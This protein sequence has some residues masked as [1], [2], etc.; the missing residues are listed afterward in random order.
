MGSFINKTQIRKEQKQKVQRKQLPNTEYIDF[1]ADL[2]E[3]IT[4]YSPFANTRRLEYVE[5]RSLLIYI[6]RDVENVTYYGIRD[7]FNSKG[8]KMDHS[9][10]LYSYVNYPIYCKYNPKITAWFNMLM[11]ASN[12]SDAKKIQAKTIIDNSD[13]AVADI[14]IYMYK[15]TK[16]VEATNLI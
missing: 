12:T 13:P 6:L 4:G 7:Y 1:L 3:T 2:I 15:K 9:T 16:D 8:K 10:A 14:F 11:D 5:V